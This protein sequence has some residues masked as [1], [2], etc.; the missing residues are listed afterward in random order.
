MGALILRDLR[1][2]W[3]NKTALFLGP[4]FF[5]IFLTLCVI[6]LGGHQE[7]LIDTSGPLIWLAVILSLFLNFS[8]LFAEDFQDGTME[9]LLLSGET[10][11]NIVLA[12]ALSFF[13]TAFLPFI[14]IV[15]LAAVVLG[16]SSQSIAAI[17]LSIIAASPA[18]I[19]YGVLTGALLAQQKSGG[20]FAVLLIAPFIVPVLIFGL[21]A[22]DSFS[23]DGLKAVE[24][25]ALAGINLIALAVAIPAAAAALKANL[26]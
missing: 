11:L 25:R 17:S 26:E 12:K 18:L 4:I 24:F 13:I 8:A 3:R 15:P 6:A 23:V 22:I 16:L 10:R 20:I 14:V 2:A 5:I 1:L 9:A 7:K 21:A 19:A